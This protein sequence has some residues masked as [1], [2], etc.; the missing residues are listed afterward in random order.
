MHDNSHLR[1]LLNLLWPPVGWYK[2]ET[3]LLRES[4]EMR[5]GITIKPLK[6]SEAPDK[7]NLQRGAY[8]HE[9]TY[10]QRIDLHA[11]FSEKRTDIDLSKKIPADDGGKTRRKAYKQR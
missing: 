4:R 7:V 1:T 3:V 6:V 5:F 9:D 8:G 10:E 2:R 11:L